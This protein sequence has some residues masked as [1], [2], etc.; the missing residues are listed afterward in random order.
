MKKKN[1]TMYKIEWSHVTLNN[2]RFT[3]QND[4]SIYN[5]ACKFTIV[6]INFLNKYS[7]N[8]NKK[9]NN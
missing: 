2:L 3:G 6:I 7:Q 9:L 5:R 8:L 1:K 4:K